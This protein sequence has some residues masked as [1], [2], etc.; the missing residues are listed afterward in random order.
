[1]STLTLTPDADLGGL[2]NHRISVPNFSISGDCTRV[3]RT[4]AGEVRLWWVDLDQVTRY[5][6]LPYGSVVNVGGW[7]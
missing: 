3:S 4:V 6:D 1:M 2:Q 7:S 5:A